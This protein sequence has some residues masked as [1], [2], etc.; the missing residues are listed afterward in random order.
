MFLYLPAGGERGTPFD[1][2]P[3]IAI[4]NLTCPEDDPI[5]SITMRD[6]NFTNTT[7][8]P[9]TSGARA[10]V[11]CQPA[12]REYRCMHSALQCANSVCI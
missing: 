9:C 4:T 7:Q 6:C 1:T 8:V 3:R 12:S 11:N 10:A 5:F 2:G